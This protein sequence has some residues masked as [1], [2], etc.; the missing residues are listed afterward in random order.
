LLF[1]VIEQG[2]A[3]AVSASAKR[4]LIVAEGADAI[5]LR[6]AV[7]ETGLEARG[8]REA[9]DAPNVAADF[10]PAVVLIDTLVQKPSPAQLIRDI[11]A[12]HNCACL[13][14]VGEATGAN[15]T[16]GNDSGADGILVK[17]L[18]P[19]AL[20][21]W[22]AQESPARFAGRSPLAA[23]DLPT[24][25]I[26]SSRE[27][28]EVWRL[29]IAAAQ[30]GSSVLLIGETGTGKEV[31][32]RA[33][34]RFSCGRGGPFVAVNCAAL[35]ENLLESE[36]FGHEKGAFTGATSQRKGRFELADGGTLFL[37]EIG[38]LP[39]SLQVKLLRVLQERSFERVGGTQTI[40]VDVRVLAAT[41]RD[42]ELE[43][44]QGRFRADLFYRLNVLCI[45]IPPLRQRP[46]DVIGLWEHFI[47]EGAEREGRPVPETS[48]AVQRALLRHTWPGN[49]RELHNVAQNVLAL[50]SGAQ[51][52][53]GDLPEALRSD[54]GATAAAH[55]LLG[56]T[57]KEIESLLIRQTYEAFGTVK[58]TAE[59]LGISPRKIHYRLKEMRRHAKSEASAADARA[60]LASLANDPALDSLHP[61][62]P[63]VLLAEDDDDLRWVL[64]NL[65]KTDGYDV[66]AV[67]DGRALLEHLG[68]AILLEHRDAPPDVIVT[69][70]RM[71]GLTGMQILESVRSRG[72]NTPVVLISA[73]ADDA[74]RRKADAL[75]ATA[76]L[77]KPIDMGEL[78]SV[79]SRAVAH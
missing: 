15:V 62:A 37:D 44:E 33:L 69:D 70:I 39:L 34:H 54:A 8:V 16:L 50:A 76:F 64:S 4:V 75:G 6:H 73:F 61:P 31:V 5:A 48:S 21:R 3:M 55:G 79:I 14:L 67:P 58:A 60:N 43:I 1:G 10:Q 18:H 13:L 52:L 51:I 53:P 42:L 36:L 12:R 38:D 7:E 68:A 28:R 25:V 47:R 71:P 27:M 24:S 78:Q 2:V 11:K 57:L 23:A 29:M 41:H 59:I 19:V 66:V 22:V 63:R 65:L 40:S 77:G 45:R 9:S 30:S 35:P 20:R 17:P 56:L 74:T 49:V 72:W 32:A 26:G 46:S